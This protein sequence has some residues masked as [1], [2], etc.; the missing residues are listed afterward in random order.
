MQ[1]EFDPEKSAAN[2]LKHG[3]DF[4]TAQGLW[5]D[6]DRI[7]VSA[8]SDTEPRFAVIGVV[9]GKHWTV[10][11]THRGEAVRIISARRSRRSE[12]E[13]YEDRG[14]VQGDQR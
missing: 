8:R 11:A 10:F 3:I 4:E 7:V 5:Q 2:L 14:Q 12:V 1:F 9:A 6:P 13:R